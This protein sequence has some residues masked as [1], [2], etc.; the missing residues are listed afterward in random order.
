M[1][2]YSKENAEIVKKFV[3]SRAMH[4]SHVVVTD[5]D[6]SGVRLCPSTLD[7]TDWINFWEDASWPHE[8]KPQVN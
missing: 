5:A 8:A 1:G 3:T 6:V 4:P 2:Y 7:Q